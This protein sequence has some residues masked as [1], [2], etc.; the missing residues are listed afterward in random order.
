MSS[1]DPYFQFAWD[2]TVPGEVELEMD[3]DT[4]GI[5]LRG[6]LT[7][8]YIKKLHGLQKGSLDYTHRTLNKQSIKQYNCKPSSILEN[9]YVLSAPCLRSQSPS[10]LV[11]DFPIVALLAL[12]V[13]IDRQVTEKTKLVNI[14]S[15]AR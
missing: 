14:S 2:S 8:D 15:S 7:D 13:S 3:D 12:T 10:G 6:L 5:S 11:P 9:P 1:R 4:L